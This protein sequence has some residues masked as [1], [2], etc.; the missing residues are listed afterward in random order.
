[1]C[2][3]P[4]SSSLIASAAAAFA[5]SLVPFTLLRGEIISCKQEIGKHYTR[6]DEEEPKVTEPAPMTTT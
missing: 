2:Q 1:V 3:D 6:D 4:R 5:P